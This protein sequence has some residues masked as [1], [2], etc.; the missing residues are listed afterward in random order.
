VQSK[1][2]NLKLF[3][4]T[5]TFISTLFASQ[6]SFSKD[7][8]TQ[9]SFFE[10]N[11]EKDLFQ[12]EIQRFILE[13]PEIIIEAI[14]RYQRNKEKEAEAEELQI[15]NDKST[16]LF[17]DDHSFVGGNN[18]GKIKIVE[19]IDYKC[20]YCKK[21]HEIIWSIIKEN[22]DVKYIVKEFPILGS[23]SIMAAQ[24]LL[25]VLLYDSNKTYKRFSDQL[26][27]HSG[28]INIKTLKAFAEL[29]GSK[30]LDLQTTMK[31]EKVNLIISKNASL[32]KKLR[33]EG[34][35][36]F[37]IEDQIIRGFIS[38]N[39]MQELIEFTRKKL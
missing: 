2:R 26:I 14:Q 34:T 36:T 4:A 5:M 18:D 13:N 1:V 6:A 39:Q 12:M 33:I 20:G 29:S 3:V 9:N 17:Q 19:F 21:N 16:E 27:A 23:Q 24:A 11:E 28:P 22:S 32:A 15:L 25:S 7:V 37:I 10:T 35:P 8:F 31:S 38:K 30:I